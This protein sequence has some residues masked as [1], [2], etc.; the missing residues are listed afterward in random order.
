MPHFHVPLQSGS[1]KIL[2]AM[3][4]RY[5]RALYKGPELQKKNQLSLMPV[6]V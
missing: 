3:R 2:S 6:L 4:R 5:K 1:E